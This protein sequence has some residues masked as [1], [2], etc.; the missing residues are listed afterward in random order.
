MKL[1]TV[2]GS[3]IIC[4]LH[5]IKDDEMNELYEPAGDEKVIQNCGKK[6]A[7]ENTIWET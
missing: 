6:T 4:T 3:F 5:Q 7:R 2:M 1:H